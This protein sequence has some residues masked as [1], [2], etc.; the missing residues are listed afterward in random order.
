MKTYLLKPKV[1]ELAE[2]LVVECAKVGYTIQI[3]QTFRTFEEQDALY[4]QGRTKPGNIV[5]N[6]KGGYSLHNYRVAFDFVPIKNGQ[7]MWNDLA[8]FDAVGKIGVR[9]GLEWGG[10]WSSFIDRPHFQYL[11]GYTLADFRAGLIDESRF[12]LRQTPLL[13]RIKELSLILLA[14]LKRKK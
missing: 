3:T 9:L 4:A 5:T 1:R 8:T 12:A 13:E 6:A 14:L 2:K 10:N 7:A 11:A